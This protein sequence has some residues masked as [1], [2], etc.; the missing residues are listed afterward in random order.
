MN[1]I[2]SLFSPVYSITRAAVALVIGLA[3]IIWPALAVYTVFRVIGAAL[4][5]LGAASVA[6]AIVN[7][8]SSDALV[9]VSGV[10]D[11]IFGLLLVIYPGFFASLLMYFLG[12]VMLVFGVG[13]IVN[14]AM[15]RRTVPVGFYWFILPFAIA[16][17]GIV[18]ICNTFKAQQTLLIVFGIALVAYAVTEIAATACTRRAEK[19]LQQTAAQ[20]AAAE[21]LR[22]EASDAEEI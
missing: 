11:I 8:T 9:M 2:K 15:L 22:E 5:V 6:L 13:Q 10:L 17:L 20:S 12:A 19:I 16:V 4:I 21:I 1:L 7:R 18:M 14:L 3:M